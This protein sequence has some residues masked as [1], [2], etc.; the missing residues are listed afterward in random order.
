MKI[1]ICGITSREDALEAIDAGAEWLGFNFYPGSRRALTL[2]ACAAI[3]SAIAERPASI[4][5]VGVFVNASAA[6][7]AAVL[8]R[9]GLDLAQLSG[10]EPPETLAALGERAFKALRISQADTAS[11]QVEALP[12]RSSP[13]TCLMDAYLPGA[14][15]G[16]GQ[17]ADWSLARRLARQA[18]ILLAGGLTPDN[19]AAAVQQVRPWG[20]DVA[21]G[22]ESSPGVKDAA[23]VRAFIQAVRA[24]TFEERVEFQA[25]AREDLADI[26]MLQKA[27][28]QS[29]AVL[30]NDF[31]IPP[32][33]QTL[34]GITDEFGRRTFLK[35]L[36][37]GQLAGSVRAHVED[38]TC[39]IGRLVVAPGR[40][41]LGLGTRLLAAIEA[42]FPDVSRYELFTSAR[43]L[44]N[45]HLYR[46]A[47]YREFRRQPLNE[48]TH[49]VYLEKEAPYDAQ[50]IPVRDQTDRHPAPG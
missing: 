19:V 46:R 45:L 11:A 33:I 12:V 5:S 16:T 14:F 37:D 50:N 29:E 26:L 1:K 43:S 32:L 18:P 35:V 31:N 20:V 21:S 38:G 23:R 13:P 42:H 28:Y 48:T 36:V 3:Q 30:N 9:C 15:G 4:V 49:L 8:D 27:A 41:N 2:E 10:D 39:H 47:G 6:A 44:R 24:V 40:Q 25:A 17:T 22:V 7:I 34:E